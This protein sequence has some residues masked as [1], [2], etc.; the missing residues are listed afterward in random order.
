L[1]IV[2]LILDI[3][4]TGTAWSTCSTTATPSVTSASAAALSLKWMVLLTI[5][6]NKKTS[7]LGRMR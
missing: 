4:A 6:A 1:A 5:P 3:R 7:V 2:I